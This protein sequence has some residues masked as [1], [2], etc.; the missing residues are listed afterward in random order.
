MRPLKHKE[1]VRPS[2][3]ARQ[4]GAAWPGVI[5][6]GPRLAAMSCSRVTRLRSLTAF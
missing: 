4:H 5:F 1:S 2:D 6:E 3:V